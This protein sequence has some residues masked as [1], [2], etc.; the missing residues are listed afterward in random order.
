MKYATNLRLSFV[1][2]LVTISSFLLGINVSNANN[3]NNALGTSK[4]F[5]ENKGQFN[6][7]TISGK[8]LEVLYAYD[9]GS[10]D[11]YF[12]KYGVVT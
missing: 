8:K 3:W 5:I 11:Y 7:Q 6:I 9:G 4:G 10:E 1:K 2:L 12:T